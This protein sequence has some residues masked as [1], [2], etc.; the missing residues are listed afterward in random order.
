[1]AYFTKTKKDS[2]YGPTALKNDQRFSI[3]KSRGNTTEKD[4]NNLN[5]EESLSIEESKNGEEYEE[6]SRTDSGGQDLIE[7]LTEDLSQKSEQYKNHFSDDGDLLVDVNSSVPEAVSHSDSS[8]EIREKQIISLTESSESLK[9]KKVQESPVRVPSH[10]EN[11]RR[12]LTSKFINPIN[13]PEKE[14]QTRY[15]F[16]HHSASISTSYQTSSTTDPKSRLPSR[17]LDSSELQNLVI[18]SSSRDKINNGDGNPKYQ[19]SSSQKKISQ[20]TSRFHEK[21]SPSSNHSPISEENLDSREISGRN[22]DSEL[23]LQIEKLREEII[24]L[25]SLLL[26]ASRKFIPSSS[27][28]SLFQE[29][30][31]AEIRGNYLFLQFSIKG[32]PDDHTARPGILNPTDGYL[33][34]IPDQKIIV[35]DSSRFG[36]DQTIKD[37]LLYLSHESTYPG[38]YIT[39]ILLKSPHEEDF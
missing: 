11:I 2:K 5:E 22:L 25:K 27:D 29:F 12:N 32:N 34:D 30:S 19:K 18:R 37:G 6:Y 26:S 21:D 20:K 36:Y 14:Q 13:V 35:Y 39:L 7:D 10:Q 4:L 3:P 24:S 16:L 33:K 17:K 8:N 23:S 15:K 28:I 1:M 31:Y 38:N 9:I